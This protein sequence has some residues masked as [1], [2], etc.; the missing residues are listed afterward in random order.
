MTRIGAAEPLPFDAEFN[1]FAGPKSRVRAETLACPTCGHRPTGTGERRRQRLDLAITW[2]YPHPT[3]PNRLVERAHCARC[4]PHQRLA[5]LDCAR[6]GDGPL[7]VGE[8][9]EFGADGLPAAPVRAWLLGRGWRLDPRP[10]CPRH[11]G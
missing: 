10:L 11:P 7:L 4:Q 1:Q 8:L 2:L 3:R 9:S 5:T 6:C